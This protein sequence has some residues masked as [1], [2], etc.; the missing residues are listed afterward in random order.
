MLPLQNEDWLLGHTTHDYNDNILSS[1]Y[2]TG[3]VQDYK[4]AIG[5]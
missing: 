3:S 5:F 2:L 4:M 1:G